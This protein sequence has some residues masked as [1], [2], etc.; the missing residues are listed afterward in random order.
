MDTAQCT[1]AVGEAKKPKKKVGRWSK[2]VE[3]EVKAELEADVIT[4]QITREG[5]HVMSRDFV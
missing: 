3:V 4:V 2:D 5:C 1:M